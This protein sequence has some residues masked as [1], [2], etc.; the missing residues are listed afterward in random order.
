MIHFVNKPLGIKLRP[1]P[2]S[3]VDY[4]FRL[5][6]SVEND[7]DKKMGPYSRWR[8]IMNKERE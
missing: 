8:E 5:K 3:K 7:D 1:D 2:L 6:L 4:Q